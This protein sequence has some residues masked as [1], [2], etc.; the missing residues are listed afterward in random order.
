MMTDEPNR[1]DCVEIDKELF[2]DLVKKWGFPSNSNYID[3]SFNDKLTTV[4]RLVPKEK[5]D[6][7]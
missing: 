7:N 5:S 3:L 1:I 4:T 6:D 2:N